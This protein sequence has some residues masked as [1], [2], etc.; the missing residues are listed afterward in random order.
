[1]IKQYLGPVQ[2]TRRV[3][4]KTPGRFFNNLTAAE[5]RAAYEVEAVEFKERH[6]FPRNLKA[7]GA[8]AQRIYVHPGAVHNLGPALAA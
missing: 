3:K 5:A 1:M 2:V 6:N 4:V 8:P 7:W